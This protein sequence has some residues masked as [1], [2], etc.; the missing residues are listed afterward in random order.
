MRSL[1]QRSVDASLNYDVDQLDNSLI[2]VLAQSDV[3]IL[4]VLKMIGVLNDLNANSDIIR[5]NMAVKY[6]QYVWLFDRTSQICQFFEFCFPPGML[7]CQ[8]ASWPAS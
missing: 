8:P 1:N 5:M 6:L 3:H 7:Y 4:T 2:E